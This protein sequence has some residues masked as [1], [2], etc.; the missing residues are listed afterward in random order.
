MAFTHCMRADANSGDVCS[1]VAGMLGN[2][3]WVGECYAEGGGGS[4]VA[5]ASSGEQ[6][7]AWFQEESIRIAYVSRSG[8]IHVE[9]ID[10]ESESVTLEDHYYYFSGPLIGQFGCSRRCSFLFRRR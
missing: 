5:L 6:K 1:M 4:C 10:L 8:V 3:G 2:A 9:N 7:R